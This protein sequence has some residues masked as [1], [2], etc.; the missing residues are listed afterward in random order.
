MKIKRYP[1]LERLAEQNRELE[2]EHDN[3]TLIL[4]TPCI[5]LW[6]IVLMVIYY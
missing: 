2:A 5:I 6:A 4:L 1:C 3:Q